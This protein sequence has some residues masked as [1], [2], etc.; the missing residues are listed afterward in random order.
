M[1]K[2]NRSV[3]SVSYQAILFFVLLFVFF[4]PMSLNLL[5]RK[6]A[7][8][9][10]ADYFYD[11]AKLLAASLAYVMWLYNRRRDLSRV[12]VFLVLHLGM[13]AVACVVNGSAT[14]NV[15]RYYYADIGFCLLCAELLR[16]NRDR[17][18]RVALA[19]FAVYTAWGIGTIYLFPKGFFSAS[20]TYDAIYGLGAKNNSFPFY[21]A[22]FFFLFVRYLQQEKRLPLR[23]P[24]LIAA[25]ILAGIICESVN[26]ILCLGLTLVMYVLCTRF[27]SVL[28]RLNPR[29]IFAVFAAVIAMVYIGTEWD[30]LQELLARLGR[31][32]TFSGRDVLWG[33]AFDHLED[34][35]FFG[36]GYFTYFTL[37]SGVQTPHAHSQWMDKLAKFGAVQGVFLVAALWQLLRQVKTGKDRLKLYTLSF[38]LLIYMLHMSFDTYN[39]NFFTMFILVINSL[40]RKDPR[41]PAPV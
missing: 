24:V 4:P 38:M 33:Q 36:N 29:A 6:M 27:K 18:L 31:S 28:I 9:K 20:S 35:P 11:V 3:V 40:S 13:M 21:F 32:V 15:L 17:F 30:A 22:F 16:T 39:Y 41:K 37:R 25:A 8:W 14:V 2:R 34:H 19:V 7:V 5:S 1:M 23:V 26:T 10:L 12:L